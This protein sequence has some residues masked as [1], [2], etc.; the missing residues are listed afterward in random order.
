MA[1]AQVSVEPYRGTEKE[2]F[3]EFELEYIGIAAIPN[4]QQAKFLQ[5]HLRVAFLSGTRTSNLSERFC[6]SH[7]PQGSLLHSPASISPRFEVTA[8]AIQPENRY[9]QELSR[10]LDKESAASI[11]NTRSRNN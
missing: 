9:Y 10:E 4:E 11:S 3:S 8:T 5:L 6:E 2:D 1:H 7:S